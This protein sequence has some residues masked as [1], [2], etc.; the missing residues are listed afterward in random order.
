MESVLK[1]DRL[2]KHY[3]SNMLRRNIE[4]LEDVSFEVMRG[5]VFGYVGHNGAGKTTTIK[6]LT[7]LIK[8]TSGSASLLGHGLDDIKAR[9]HIGY[10]PENSYYYDYLTAG[11][12][13]H[14]YGKLNGMESAAIRKK[15]DE[16]FEMLNLT[17]AKNRPLR[18]FSKG[19]LQRV[20]VAQ[21]I[22]HDPEL[23]IMDEP[24]SGLDPIG[25][26]QIKEIIRMLRKQGRTIFFASH[27]L[28][29]VE[30][31][32]DRVALL[33]RGRLVKIGSIEEMTLQAKQGDEF[34]FSGWNEE[35]LKK[36]EPHANRGAKIEKHGE[37]LVVSTPEESDKEEILKLATCS[38]G[39]KLNS[40][41][42]K[43]LSLED[44]FMNEYRVNHEDTD[45]R[46]KHA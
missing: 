20:G 40:M 43:R 17:H 6:I 34:N 9:R 15:T 41:M 13:M 31:L 2:T 37:T 18:E 22:L 1:T 33:A 28:S 27:I 11:E 16:L 7:G 19:M 24:M 10:L 39:V 38:D 4:A 5:E 45:R 44:I 29:D 23:V 32:C 14:F 42:Q 21:A 8:A 30:Q 46:N 26:I 3:K 25:R 35:F 36:L 12:I